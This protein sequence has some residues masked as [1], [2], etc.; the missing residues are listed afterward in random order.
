MIEL[1]WAKKTKKTRVPKTTPG[2]RPLIGGGS[3]EVTKIE[4]VLQYRVRG[5][6]EADYKWKDVP[7]ENE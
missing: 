4:K 7:V 3:R 5:S 2:G 1:R 6:N